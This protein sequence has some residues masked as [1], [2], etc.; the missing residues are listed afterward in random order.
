MTRA[1]AWQT[2]SEFLDNLRPD[3]NLLTV[4]GRNSRD[5]AVILKIKNFPSAL[6]SLFSWE[7]TLW[8]DFKPFLQAEDIKN[9][10]QFAFVDDIIKNNDARVFKNVNGKIILGYSIFSK[11]YVIISTSRDALSTILDRLIA[12]PPR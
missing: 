7:R 11:Q 4:Y 12:L 3:F 8:Q 2:P 9:I 1:L 6:A 5:I 10:S